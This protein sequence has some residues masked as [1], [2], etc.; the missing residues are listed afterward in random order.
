MS[1]VH[2]LEGVF[3]FAEVLID[4]IAK[5]LE[6]GPAGDSLREGRPDG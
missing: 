3:T 2:T 4:N 5:A 6:P 1:T